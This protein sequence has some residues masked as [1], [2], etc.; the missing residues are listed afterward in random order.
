MGIEPIARCSRAV[1]FE[2]QGSHQAPIAST[3]RHTASLFYRSGF[4]FSMCHPLAAGAI[5]AGNVENA[6]AAQWRR[7][8]EVN[9]LAPLYT[10]HAA[11]RPMRAQGSGNIINIGSLACRQTSPIYNP[12]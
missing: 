8:I 4:A 3:A 5:Q 10:C 6:D 7:V 1:G 12:Y 9:L 2:D 11:L